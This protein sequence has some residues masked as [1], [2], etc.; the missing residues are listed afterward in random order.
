MNYSDI[1]EKFC[2]K[3][4]ETT[5]LLHIVRLDVLYPSNSFD[6]KIKYKI[7]NEKS[8][9]FEALPAYEKHLL[10]RHYGGGERNTILQNKAVVSSNSFF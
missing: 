7:P 5:F 4:L 10:N 9:L 3:N 8:K 6:S 1:I 2:I